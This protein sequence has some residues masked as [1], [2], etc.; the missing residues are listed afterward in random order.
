[1]R[2]SKQKKCPVLQLLEKFSWGDRTNAGFLYHKKEKGQ[3]S[4]WPGKAII[5]SKPQPN[6]MATL[7]VGGIE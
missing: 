5:L 6:L 4:S 2:Y 3:T 1:M 7:T